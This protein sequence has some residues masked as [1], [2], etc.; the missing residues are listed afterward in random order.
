MQRPLAG[1]GGEGRGPEWWEP[2]SERDHGH[3]GGLDLRTSTP[4]TAAT[5]EA[6]GKIKGLGSKGHWAASHLALAF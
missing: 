6:A 4:D 5:Q 3:L 1:Q 2:C